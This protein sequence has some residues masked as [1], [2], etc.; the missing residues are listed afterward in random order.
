MND[1]VVPLWKDSIIE[2]ARN[3]EAAYIS[4]FNRKK[5]DDDEFHNE[6]HNYIER[7]V[8]IIQLWQKASELIYDQV[9]KTF[10]KTDD[11]LIYTMVDSG[12]RGNWNQ[13]SQLAGIKGFVSN[14]SE[15]NIPVIIT[16]NYK[17]GLSPF[18]Y[19]RTASR[20]HMQSA[21]VEKYNMDAG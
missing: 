14:P 21:Q 19:F 13:L 18:D 12:A 3:K 20:M 8:K 5:E 11:S 9:I 6:F 10:E 15:E 16:K 1:I 7:N 2:D 17:E 4:E